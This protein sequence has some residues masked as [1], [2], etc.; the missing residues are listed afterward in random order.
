MA[1]TKATARDLLPVPQPPGFHPTIT[2]TPPS[3]D[4]LHFW[5]FISLGLYRGIFAMG[6][7]AGPAH[8]IYF[9]VY[10]NCKERF[11]V[12]GSGNGNAVARAGVVATVASDA[13]FTPMDMVKQRLQLSNSLYSGVLDCVRRVVN[14]EGYRTFY[15]SYRTTVSGESVEDERL[16]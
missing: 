14:E 9:S 5:K 11:V 7:G 4:G 2:V 15:A 6:L 3:H 1:T 8:A 12:E 16:R 13:V 10:E